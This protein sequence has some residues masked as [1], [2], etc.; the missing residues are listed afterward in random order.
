YLYL[1]PLVLGVMLLWRLVPRGGWIARWPLAL[2]VGTF[3]GLKLV[4]FLDADFVAQIRATIVPLAVMT[5][6]G[7]DLWASLRNIG[8]LIGVLSCLTYFYFSV[9]HRGVI[10]KI[11]RVGIWF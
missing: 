7:F 4:N 11:S 10:G 2:V 5:S 3:A 1:V 6:G 9:E 8:L